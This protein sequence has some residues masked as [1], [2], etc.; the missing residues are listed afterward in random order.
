MFYIFTGTIMILKHF[1]MSYTFVYT[2]CFF[3]I[4]TWAISSTICSPIKSD[5]EHWDEWDWANSANTA[6]E[7]GAVFEVLRLSMLLSILTSFMIS[8]LLLES[9]V[10]CNLGLLFCLMFSKRVTFFLFFKT[11]NSIS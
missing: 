5:R 6:R 10:D 7:L 1:I 4:L 3:I 9:L 2:F 8:F 11:A